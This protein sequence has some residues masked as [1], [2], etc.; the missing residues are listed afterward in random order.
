MLRAALDRRVAADGAVGLFEVGGV[1]GAAGG[2]VTGP[3]VGVDSSAGVSVGRPSAD[4]E[5]VA[6]PVG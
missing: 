5:T 4:R 1:V 3:G 6:S 2:G